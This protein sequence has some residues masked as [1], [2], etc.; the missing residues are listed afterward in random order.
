VQQEEETTI[1]ASA[2]SL[3]NQLAAS[4]R[5]QLA[6]FLR[7]Q[8]HPKR[9]RKDVAGARVYNEVAAASLPTNRLR[10]VAFLRIAKYPIGVAGVASLPSNQLVAFCR[11]AKHPKRKEVAGVASLPT[12]RLLAFRK[13]KHPKKDVAGVRGLRGK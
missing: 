9:K 2:A 7:K 6:A 12:N 8:N 4:L 10:V 5:N 3:R 11:I 13:P 1:R